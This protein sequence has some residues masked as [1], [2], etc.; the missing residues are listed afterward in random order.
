[1]ENPLKWMRTGAPVLGNHPMTGFMIAYDNHIL[2]LNH[3]GGQ[4]TIS[5][6]GAVA[7]QTPLWLDD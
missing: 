3:P 2:F 7:A 4:G 1:M 5:S 6:L